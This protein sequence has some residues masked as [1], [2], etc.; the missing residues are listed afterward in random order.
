MRSGMRPVKQ[1]TDLKSQTRFQV[2]VN[3]AIREIERMLATH[4]LETAWPGDMIAPVLTRLVVCIYDLAVKCE[5]FVGKPINF[6]DDVIIKAEVKDA[7]S[8]IKFTR[9][10]LC[11]VAHSGHVTDEGFYLSMNATWGIQAPWIEGT[12]SSD[13]SDDVAFF[14][15]EQRVYFRRHL[16]RAFREAREN[17]ET[18]LKQ[19]PQNPA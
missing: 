7:Y 3:A 13:Y 11:H 10:A 12:P 2:D 14:F 16:L 18:F 4:I 1:L 6:T 17:L 9:D 19:L 15:G 8:L 5:R